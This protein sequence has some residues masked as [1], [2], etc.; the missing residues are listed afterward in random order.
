MIKKTSSIEVTSNRCG[1]I[2]DNDEYFILDKS[3]IIDALKKAMPMKAIHSDGKASC[4]VCGCHVTDYT[5]QYCGHCGQR[6]ILGT[7][8]E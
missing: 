3:K 4:C 1:S 6:L 8:I 2:C 5:N 7:V